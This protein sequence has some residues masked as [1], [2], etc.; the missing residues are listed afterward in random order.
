[1]PKYE[2]IYET[3]KTSYSTEH[4]YADKVNAESV[5]EAIDISLDKHVKKGSIMLTG[6]DTL[7]S[8]HGLDRELHEKENMTDK[9]FK[10]YLYKLI[11]SVTKS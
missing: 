6:L 2:V 1:M 8:F 7:D 11:S 3:P 9:E 4:T 10:E 5:K